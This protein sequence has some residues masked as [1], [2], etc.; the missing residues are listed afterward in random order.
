M[1]EKEEGLLESLDL[2]SFEGDESCEIEGEEL[3]AVYDPSSPDWT[4]FV[5]SQL[6]DSEKV[7]DKPRAIG[8]VRVVGQVLSPIV[9]N[10][11][12]VHVVTQDYAAVTERIRLQNGFVASGSAEVSVHN[13]QEPYSKYPLASASTRAL[14]R[15]V[16]TILKLNVLTAEEGNDISVGSNEVVEGKI[17]D[18]QTRF[19]DILSQR[20]SINPEKSAGHILGKEVQSLTDLTHGEAL[21]IQNEL[22]VW[23]NDKAL[24][25][26]VGLF[27]DEKKE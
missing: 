27:V 25:P 20:I 16:K 3:E 14:G 15:A 11:T 19:I 26:D 12:I 24:V 1:S 18:T 4:E 8:L 13:C 17:S 22:E 2:D 21:L 9:E 5:M 6:Q 23:A 7:G 10:E